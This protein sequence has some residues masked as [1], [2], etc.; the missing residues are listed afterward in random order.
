[1]VELSVSGT[2]SE[3][4]TKIATAGDIGDGC[5]RLEIGVLKVSLISPQIEAD[6]FDTVT[7]R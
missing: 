4:S 2:W 5:Y 1:M 7:L 3:L 6:N